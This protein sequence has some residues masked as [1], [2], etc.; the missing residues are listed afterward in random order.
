[1]ASKQVKRPTQG[2]KSEKLGGATA[3]K[4]DEKS[5]AS[6]DDDYEKGKTTRG[7]ARAEINADRKAV[8]ELDK[9]G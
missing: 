8:E 1:M 7:G 6:N 2:D 3:S 5:S 4:R 9:W